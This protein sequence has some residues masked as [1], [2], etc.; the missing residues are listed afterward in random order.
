MLDRNEGADPTHFDDRRV[1]D[2]VPSI[3]ISRWKLFFSSFLFVS[4]VRFFTFLINSGK[5]LQTNFI[6]PSENQCH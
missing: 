1:F 3:A 4:E 5:P 6:G 2:I